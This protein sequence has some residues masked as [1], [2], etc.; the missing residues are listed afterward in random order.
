MHSNTV[1]IYNIYTYYI[2]TEYIFIIFW[3]C[4]AEAASV[5]AGIVGGAQFS[6]MASTFTYL[7]FSR[8]VRLQVPIGSVAAVLLAACSSSAVM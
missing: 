5:A 1:Y 6:N 4:T 2:D 3:P 8:E 7:H